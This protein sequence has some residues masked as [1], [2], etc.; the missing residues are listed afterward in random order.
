MSSQQCEALKLL[1][2]V[3][4]SYSEIANKTPMVKPLFLFLLWQEK[5]LPRKTFLKIA[6][7]LKKYYI[8]VFSFENISFRIPLG[9]SPNLKKTVSLEVTPKIPRLI[10]TKI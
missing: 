2:V 5:P 9:E 1:A 10:L 3:L 8:K 4:Q 7:H 6:T